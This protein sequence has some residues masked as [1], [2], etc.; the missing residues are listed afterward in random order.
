MNRPGLPFRST[1]AAKL[2]TRMLVGELLPGV[3]CGTLT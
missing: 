3:G 2:A 1:C